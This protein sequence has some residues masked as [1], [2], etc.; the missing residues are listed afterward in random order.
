MSALNMEVNSFIWKLY[1]LNRCGLNANLQFNAYE[2]RIYANL[3]VD[4]GYPM[5]DWTILDDQRRN[6]FSRS[7]IRRRAR[8]RKQQCNSSNDVDVTAM[9]TV[10]T[11]HDANNCDVSSFTPSQSSD[12]VDS[13]ATP[14][15]LEPPSVD[16][17]TSDDS[18]SLP[19]PEWTWT[20]PTE[21]D[22]LDYL[23]RFPQSSNPEP[24][25]SSALH[26]SPEDLVADYKHTDKELQ[27]MNSGLVLNF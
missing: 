13:E 2:G 3:S 20:E 8:R 21:E 26:G 9:N 19:D 15:S 23:R 22:I 14:L 18:E 1:Q 6:R 11:N 16:Q 17:L 12:V 7:R 5:H 25:N 27:D 4:L 24:P 10:T